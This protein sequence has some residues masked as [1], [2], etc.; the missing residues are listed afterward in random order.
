MHKA[1]YKVY[2]T[3][4]LVGIAL[5]IPLGYGVRF[6]PGLGMPLLQDIFGSLAYQIL[7]MLIFTFFYPRASLVKVAVWVCVA[8]CV[9]ELLQLW[10]P[11][12]LQAIRATW[13]GRIVLGNTFTLSDFPPYAVGSFLGWLGLKWLRRKMVHPFAA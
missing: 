11:P 7:L 5:I 1:N 9:S 3:A 12:F 8:S 13:L 2:R 4:L 10:Q 6:A